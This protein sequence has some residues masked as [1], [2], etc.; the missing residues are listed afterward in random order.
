MTALP[1]SMTVRLPGTAVLLCAGAMATAGLAQDKPR[2][3]A[4]TQ[5]CGLEATTLD[6]TAPDYLPCA[7]AVRSAMDAI[8]AQSGRP[9]RTARGGDPLDVGSVRT[10]V[11]LTFPLVDPAV[12]DLAAFATPVRGDPPQVVLSRHA[13]GAAGD[14]RLAGHARTFKLLRGQLLNPGGFR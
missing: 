4:G 10:G 12:A 11:L 6:G 1:P 9:E 3:V 13:V 14:E 2:S 8:L 7:I 5:P